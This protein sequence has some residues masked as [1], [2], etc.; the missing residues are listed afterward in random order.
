MLSAHL[1]H[2]GISTGEVEGDDRINNGAMDN[3][4][5]TASMIEVAKLFQKNGA[6][7]R[8]SILFVA[9]TAEEKGLIGSEYFALNP[10]VPKGSMVA[11]VNLDMPI[12]T[13]RFQDLVSYGGDRS[14]IGPVVER[15]LAKHDLTLTPRS[16]PG[17]GR[18]RAQRSLQLRQG[19][20]PRSISL[21]TGPK[22]PGACGDR[23]FPRPSLSPAVGTR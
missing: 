15:V 16:R 19:G 9:V 4:M 7:P 18:V 22:G 13:Y 17:T 5:G 20:H 6:K 1:D 23:G 14:S 3:A 10:T 21:E 8:R 11:D 12:L 2:I